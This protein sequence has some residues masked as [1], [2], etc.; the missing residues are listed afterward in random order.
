MHT[1]D[2]AWAAL[3]RGF[4]TLM[5]CMGKLTEEELTAPPVVGKWTVKDVVAHVWSWMDE[6]GCTAKAWRDRRPWQQ[7][8]TFD[9]AWNEHQVRDR[10][11]ALDRRGGRAD[12]RTSRLMH[13]LDL[14]EDE[15]LAEVGQG[16][17]GRGDAAGRFLLT[18]MAEHYMNMPR[19]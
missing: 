17:L 14:A 6:A 3:D 4:K 10:T 16:A 13:L 5:D 19:I 2:E 12:G 18:S 9:D 8:V 7:G 1:R 15:A 11:A